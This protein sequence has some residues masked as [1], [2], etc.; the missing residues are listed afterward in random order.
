V[1]HDIT[2]TRDRLHQ[3]QDIKAVFVGLRDPL[4]QLRHALRKWR[5]IGEPAPPD[6]ARQPNGPCQHAHRS[7]CCQKFQ[8]QAGP[9]TDGFVQP[10]RCKLADDEEHCEPMQYNARW[11][12]A[13]AFR[14]RL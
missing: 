3:E 2:E 9:M 8:S 11:V 5:Q 12:E 7:V 4:L 6:E 14:R 13:L 1:E 10:N